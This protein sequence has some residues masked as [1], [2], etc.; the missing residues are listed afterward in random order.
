MALRNHLRRDQTSIP[1]QHSSLGSRTLHSTRW[2]LWS[3]TRVHVSQTPNAHQSAADSNNVMQPSGHNQHECI[4]TSKQTKTSNHKRTHS[5]T[6]RYKRE[7]D[8]PKKVIQANRSQ[9]Q[10]LSTIRSQAYSSYPRPPPRAL[11]YP[12]FLPNITSHTSPQP[13]RA[14]QPLKHVMQTGGTC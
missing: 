3:K 6:E 14:C 9:K 11:S 12:D 5:T 8:L 4:T 13:N 10:R 1:R 7:R 2:N